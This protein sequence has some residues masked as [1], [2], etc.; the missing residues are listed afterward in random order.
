MK[1]AP[2]IIPT[3]NRHKHFKRLIESLRKNPIAAYTDLYISVDFPPAQKYE[4]GYNRICE[5]LSEGLEGFASVNIYYQEKNLGAYYNILFLIEIVKKSYDYFILTEDDNEFA[6]NYLDYMNQQLIRYI[7]DDEVFG[8]Y[9]ASPK[10]QGEYKNS[11]NTHMVRYYSAYGI[12]IWTKK[13]ILQEKKI[14]RDYIEDI[15]CSREILSAMARENPIT[16]CALASTVLRKERVYRNPDGTVPLID[17]VY[18]IYAIAEN[19]YIVCSKKA[20]VKNGGYDGSGD[21]CIKNESIGIARV[22]LGDE[23]EYTCID[24]YPVLKYNLKKENDL[25]LK[26]AVILSRIKLCIWRFIAKR[27]LH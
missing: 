1:Y 20:L 26:I 18:M 23:N 22:V 19:K 3:L 25:N 12:G 13:W 21:N 11:N 24:T 16:I 2:I 8:V 4:E 17:M 15:A 5:Y 9:S 27:E 14:T 10:I 7:D 6:P